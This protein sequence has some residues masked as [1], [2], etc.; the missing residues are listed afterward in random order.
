LVKVRSRASSSSSV[1]LDVVRAYFFSF[2][3]FV[4]VR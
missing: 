1:D 2:V 3:A 4:A